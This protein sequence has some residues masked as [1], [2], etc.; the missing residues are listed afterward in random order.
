M[1]RWRKSAACSGPV[2]CCWP[3]ASARRRCR[4]CAPPGPPRTQ[5]VHVNEFVDMHDLGSAL[6]RAGFSEPVL[7]VDRHLRHYA[8]A[9]ALMRE[10]K[11]IGAHNVHA[12]RRRGLTGRAAF[13]RMNAA[14]ET[15]ARSRRA[16]LPPGRWCTRWPGSPDCARPA[17]RTPRRRSPHRPRTAARQP[18][19]P[20][21]DGCPIRARAR[22]CSSPAPTPA[23]ARPGSRPGCCAALAARRRTGP[24][25]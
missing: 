5:G 16:C 10:L 17:A 8:D 4:S 11:A 24:P 15:H 7:D 12:Q 25:A 3:A 18:E 21:D 6:Q 14:Y 1:L 22:A 20:R 19:E 13:Q 9:R 2:A 23:S